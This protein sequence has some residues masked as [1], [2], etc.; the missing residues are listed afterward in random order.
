MGAI[1]ISVYPAKPQP[2][3]LIENVNWMIFLHR[4]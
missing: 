2:I 1:S 4:Q 3:L